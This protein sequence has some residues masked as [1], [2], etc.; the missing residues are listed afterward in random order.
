MKVWAWLENG[1]LKVSARRDYAPAHVIELEAF[2]LEDVVYE[3]GIIRL[4][5][6]REKLSEEKIRKKQDIES[7]IKAYIEQT[8]PEI[9]Q[10][11]DV[12]DKEFYGSWLIT[13][14]IDVNGNPAYTTDSLYKKAFI[15]GQQIWFGSKTLTQIL[16]EL[17]AN[18]LSNLNPA[19]TYGGTRQ[20]WEKEFLFAWEQLIKISVRVAFVQACK[21][22][23]RRLK[24]QIEQAQSLQELD[25]IQIPPS[26][27]PVLPE[28]FR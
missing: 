8:Y 26:N 14:V 23:Y 5:T 3:K 20:S 15:Y 21:V 25:K 28:E 16:Q 7:I 24:T 9:K 13:N 27:M 11:S 17:Q 10:R 1:I 2:S 18:E 22:I 4:K 6:E 12:A 19:G